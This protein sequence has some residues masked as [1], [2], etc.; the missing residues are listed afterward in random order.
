MGYGRGKPAYGTH[1]DTLQGMGMTLLHDTHNI[2]SSHL[3]DD[4]KKGKHPNACPKDMIFPDEGTKEKSP[5]KNTDDGTRD[6][7]FD[8]RMIEVPTIVKQGKY[9][10]NNQQG[11]QK[12]CGIG[13][14]DRQGHK[15]GSKYA[16]TSGKSCF[17]NAK[18]DDRCSR[19]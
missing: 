5:D 13:Y 4:E 8:A 15:R 1:E 7:D 6:E 16:N 17:G 10:G 12:R 9:V 18:Q 11:K 19:T 14:T 3:E 2:G